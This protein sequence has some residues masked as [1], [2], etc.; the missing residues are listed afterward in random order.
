VPLVKSKSLE[1]ENSEDCDIIVDW[2]VT[3]SL[4]NLCSDSNYDSICEEIECIRGDVEMCD[5]CEYELNNCA[6]GDPDK[7]YDE[8]R[9]NQMDDSGS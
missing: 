2:L 4:I 7:Y 1:I 9:D 6:C 8:W 5:T 3:L